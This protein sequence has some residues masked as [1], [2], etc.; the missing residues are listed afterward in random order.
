[1]C[2]NEIYIKVC[3]ALH[4]SDIFSTRNARKSEIFIPTPFQ[5]A[6]QWAIRKVLGN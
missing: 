1:M 2:L 5:L 4:F 3:I 6:L